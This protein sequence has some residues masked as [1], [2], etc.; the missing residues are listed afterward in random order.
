MMCNDKLAVSPSGPILTSLSRR[1]CF[2][3]NGPSSLLDDAH[4]I[5]RWILI[6]LNK[7]ISR[8]ETE[9]VRPPGE[10]RSHQSYCSLH[11]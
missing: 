10:S 5:D 6:G 4:Q 7:R 11:P 1:S 9:A 8:S 3:H 2:P